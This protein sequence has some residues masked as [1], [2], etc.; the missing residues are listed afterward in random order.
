MEIKI[1]VIDLCTCIREDFSV[2][3][4]VSIYFLGFSIEGFVIYCISD[5]SCNGP[6]F[7]CAF[8]RRLSELP[9]HLALNDV[10]SVAQQ[11]DALLLFCAWVSFFRQQVIHSA[12]KGS[13]DD[14]ATVK[15][16]MCLSCCCLPCHLF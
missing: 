6:I 11:E 3:S 12:H 10:A 2:K 1:R 13:H 5:E 4:R 14:T 7:Q 16:F 15:F 9:E 8:V